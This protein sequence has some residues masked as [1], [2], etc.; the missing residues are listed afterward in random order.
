M[1]SPHRS[2]YADR[3]WHGEVPVLEN[4]RVARD[5]WRL[6][7]GCQEIA[8][9][10]LPGQF[11]MLRLVDGDDPLLGRPLAVYDRLSDV[12]GHPAMLDIVYLTIGKMTGRLAGVDTGRRLQIWGPLGNGFQPCSAEHLIMVAG[13][14]GQ[15]PFLSLAQE[16]LGLK[17]YGEPARQVPPAKKVTLCYGA[18][19]KDFF[20]GVED[21]RQ[22]GVELRLST[23]DGS[24][25]HHGLVTE[26]LADLARPAAGGASP[27]PDACRIVCCGPEPMMKATARIAREA[28][29][30]C[31]VSLETP[32]AC[33]VG[34]C[35]SC[36][37]KVR[38]SEANWDYRRTCVEGPVFDAETIE[39][40]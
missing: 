29:I 15:T 25:G 4:V 5:T 26:V 19:S 18:R 7:V 2:S 13:G 28:G 11:V 32:M 20:A 31:E 9:R 33:G 1:N 24:A 23:D 12:D 17:T 27:S 30:R 21:F 14:I 3:V 37:V 34:I 8:S 38:D 39:F 16:Y 35:F 22:A 10:F 6:R 40:S 36:V